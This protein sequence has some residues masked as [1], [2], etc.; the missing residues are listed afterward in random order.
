LNLLLLYSITNDL[1]P[2]SLP[3][4]SL[5]WWENLNWEVRF[6]SLAQRMHVSSS[7][8]VTKRKW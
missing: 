8:Q 1:G 4:Q 7:S 2:T 3:S 6:F 5:D